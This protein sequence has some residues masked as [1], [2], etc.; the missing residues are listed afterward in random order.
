MIRVGIIIGSSRS[1]RNGEAVGRWVYDIARRR[2]DAEFE[3]VDIQDFG[4]QVY[5]EPF[6]L[7]LGQ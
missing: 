1:G 2:S 4:L 3:L 6:P 7:S 5:D